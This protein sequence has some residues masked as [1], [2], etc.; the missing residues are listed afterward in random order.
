MRSPHLNSRSSAL[1]R[2]TAIAAA[3]AALFVTQ[4]QAANAAAD[5]KPAAAAKAAGGPVLPKLSAEQIAERSVTA[6]GGAGAWHAIQSISYTG[7]LDAGKIRPDNGMNPASREVLLEK[8]GKPAKIAQAPESKPANLDGGTPVSLPYAM[9][10]ARPNKQRVEVKFQDETLVQVYDG[11]SGWK[12]QPYLKRG[13]AL[14]FTAEE[15]KK[16]QQFQE[17]DG[18]L[19]DYARKGTKLALDGTETVEGRP[20][21]RLKLTLKSGEIQDIWIDA[22]T[23][24][25]V[26]VEGVPHR[27]DGKIRKVYIV[28]HDFRTVQ[29]LKVPYE[30]VTTVEGYPDQHKMNL[31]Q[32]QLNPILGDEL[33]TRPKAGKV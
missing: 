30:L 18:L 24:L 27:M 2:C 13:G 29:G 15:M 14:P 5:A 1:A 33:F 26:K 25:D 32:V 17:I 28:Q 4:A 23:F 10:M 9:Y 21:Y 3:V 8:P 19:V 22:R 11:K 20:A 12:L 7:T 16:A 6:Q 31:E